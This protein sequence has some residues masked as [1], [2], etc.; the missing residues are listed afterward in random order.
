MQKTFAVNGPVALDVRLA[1]GEIDIDPT[2][3][4]Q[5]E[6]EL[7]GHDE[8]SRKLVDDA[9]VELQ[10]R[11]G[12]EDQLIVDVPNRRGGGFGL[13]IV[14]GRQGVSCR[15][16]CPEGSSVT[17]RTKSA[18]LDVQ[19]IVGGLNH[20]TASGDTRADRIRGNATVKTASGDVSLRE[21]HGS[22]NVQ[23]ASGDVE[24]GS[25]HGTL[26]VAS[27]SG[28]VSIDEAGDDANVNTVSGDQQL[29][30][31]LRGAITSQSV[32][33]DVQIGVRRGSK[34]FL[35]CNTLSGD[36]SSELEVGPDAPEG[37]GPL[38][39]VRAKTVSGDISITRAPAPAAGNSND[40]T[41]EV[42]A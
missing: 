29:G 10:S 16:R 1:S 5:V 33:G 26:S 20:A 9:R 2:L 21:V 34:V 22:A 30:A 36:T 14:F 19:G 35:D 12:G 42:H 18:D 25:V 32:S 11:P 39:E 40:E 6:L 31:V 4:D 3:E 15:I 13:S 37:D 24:I 27:A 7:V 28:D 23:S 8:E 17:A 41:Q 38:V